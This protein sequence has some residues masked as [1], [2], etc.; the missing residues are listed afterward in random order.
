MVIKDI[1]KDT[2]IISHGS[3]I[4]YNYLYFGAQTMLE[5]SNAFIDLHDHIFI[6]TKSQ[7]AALLIKPMPFERFH[8]THAQ[9]PM[10][11]DVIWDP[12][13]IKKADGYYCVSSFV[14]SQK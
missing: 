4:R 6:T 8:K 13:L 5:A 11:V 7:E 10:N 2:N 12:Q 14:M 1:P 3:G 9:K